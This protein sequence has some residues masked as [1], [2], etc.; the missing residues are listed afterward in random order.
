[1]PY[2]VLQTNLTAPSVEQ[3]Q[4]AFQFVEGL[5]RYDARILGNDAFGILAKDLS[6]KQAGAMQGALRVE[7]LE[8]EIVDQSFLPPV[9]P[10][11]FVQRCEPLPEHLL[12]YDPL[13]R[14]FSLE[15][16]HVLIV[17]AGAVRVTEF[18]QQRKARPVT[19]YHGDGAQSVDMEYET[20]SK[21][22]QNSRLLG[23]IIVAG[24]SLRYSVIADQMNFAYLGERKVGNPIGNFSLFL[25]D[26]V[27]FSSHAYVNR[28][29][30]VMQAEPAKSFNYPSKNAFYEEIIWMLWQLKKAA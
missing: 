25:R 27:R 28:G 21:E 5:T 24:G 12:I 14:S 30:E 23:E 18:V 22:Q 3:L 15:W 29:A 16:P 17:A 10:T 2:A 13:G 20:V 26:L 11:R 4:R 7:G 9:P 8:T 19:R 6:A 1:M